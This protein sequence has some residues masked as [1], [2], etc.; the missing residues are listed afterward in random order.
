MFGVFHH[1]SD[2]EVCATLAGL[3]RVVAPGGRFGLLEAVWP[4]WFWDLPGYVLRA[5]DRGKYVRSKK[6]WCRLLGETWAVSDVRVTR[7]FVIEYFGCTLTP[8]VAQAREVKH[9]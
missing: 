6:A 7:N 2:A 3:A 8:A 4:S 1:L 9:V 5:L